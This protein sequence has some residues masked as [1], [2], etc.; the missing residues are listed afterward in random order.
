M[1]RSPCC[2]NEGL[3]RGAWTVH[4]DKILSEYIKNHGEGRWRNLPQKAGLKRCGKSCRL[5]W[6][7]YLRPD[8]K[9][10]NIS[11]D[12]EELIIRLHKLLGNRW[13][14][15]A[16]RLPGRTDNEIKNYWNTNLGKKVPLV[17]HLHQ[18]TSSNTTATTSSNQSKKP[19]TN[20]SSSSPG[21]APLAEMGAHVVRTKAIK[22]STTAGVFLNYPKPNRT[23]EGV[24]DH[25]GGVVVPSKDHDEDKYDVAS[26]CYDIN[27]VVQGSGLS[28]FDDHE[29]YVNAQDT[30]LSQNK[31]FVDQMEEL[32][33]SDLLNSDYFDFPVHDHNFVDTYNYNVS[34]YNHPKD[35]IVG[36]HHDNHDH[37]LLFSQGYD[38]ISTSCSSM[39]V[40][41]PNVGPDFHSNAEG[42]WLAD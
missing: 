32:C 21:K 4:E 15:I 33:L 22:C 17:Q 14:L 16:G 2:S 18:T 8:I 6:L 11:P 41:D 36:D 40:I 39:T 30:N 23:D 5:R 9:R 19:K 37:D 38:W 27:S 29:Y 35:E 42:D 13:S 10:G 25:A 3:N 28:A 34:T 20:H 24:A 1:G 31:Y 26:N 7:N 12:E